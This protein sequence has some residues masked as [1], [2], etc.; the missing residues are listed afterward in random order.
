MN[1]TT[2]THKHL[3]GLRFSHQEALVILIGDHGARTWAMLS[4]SVSHL[5]LQPLHLEEA[6]ASSLLSTSQHCAL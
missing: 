3:L 1:P 5:E 2:I 4:A 6:R